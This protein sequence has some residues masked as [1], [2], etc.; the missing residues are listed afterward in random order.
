MADPIRA[1]AETRVARTVGGPVKAAPG[2]PPGV[3]PGVTGKERTF[4]QS[5]QFGPGAMVPYPNSKPPAGPDTHNSKP[6]NS[7]GVYKGTG[8]AGIPLRA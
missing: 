4:Q 3:E 5:R 2:G 8:R 1:A 6:S 7:S